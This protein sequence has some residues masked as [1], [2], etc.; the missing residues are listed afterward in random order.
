MQAI[1]REE[2]PSLPPQ[3]QNEQSTI[4]DMLER[5]CRGCWTSDPALRPTMRDI[6]RDLRPETWFLQEDE[7][8]K[9]LAYNDVISNLEKAL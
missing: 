5:I 8:P 9:H 6:V 2:V 4:R 3:S 7:S 1:T